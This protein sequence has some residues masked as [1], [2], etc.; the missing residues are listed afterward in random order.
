MTGGE[1]DNDDF[2]HGGGGEP[3][4]SS[5]DNLCKNI[6][7]KVLRKIHDGPAVTA[8]SKT[9][10]S[11]GNSFELDRNEKKRKKKITAPVAENPSP[12]ANGKEQSQVSGFPI[13]HFAAMQNSRLQSG[14]SK[15]SFYTF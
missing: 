1:E 6:V 7:E 9:T 10:T 4:E 14:C 12:T 11:L 15:H 3:G 8:A 2:E 13:L 5:L